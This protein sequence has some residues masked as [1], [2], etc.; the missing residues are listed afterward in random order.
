MLTEKLTAAGF[1]TK[2]FPDVDGDVYIK[3]VKL[4]HMPHVRTHLFL[5][6]GIQDSDVVTIDV[7]P[8]NDMMVSMWDWN[9]HEGPFGCDTELGRAILCEAGVVV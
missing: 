6:I 4:L 9:S 1:Y 7:Y 3:E 8:Q 2:K 5:G